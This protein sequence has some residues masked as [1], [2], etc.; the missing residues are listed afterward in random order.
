MTVPVRTSFV[1]IERP[2]SS[3][4]ATLEFG[5]IAASR[6]SS[7]RHP[8]R[9]H[10]GTGPA[11]R[12][13]SAKTSFVRCTNHDFL[14]SWICFTIWIRPI[15]FVGNVYTYLNFFEPYSSCQPIGVHY[16]R[17]LEKG[18]K[19]FIYFLLFREHMFR[20][21]P[22]V[23]SSI[24]ESLNHLNQSTNVM[25]FKSENWKRCSWILYC[26]GWD[27]KYRTSISLHILKLLRLNKS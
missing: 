22:A 24:V 23:L 15:N 7:S 8:H 12:P 19:Y 6:G 4:Q 13:V 10:A 5:P 25:K 1:I 16:R 17:D 3:P 9:R 20:H 11:R 27:R 21:S 18:W 2:G 14:I 26:S